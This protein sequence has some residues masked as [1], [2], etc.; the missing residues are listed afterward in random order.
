[1]SLYPCGASCILCSQ[2]LLQSSQTPLQ[3]FPVRLNSFK[4]ETCE[5]KKTPSPICR[6]SHCFALAVF[7]SAAIVGVV[8]GQPSFVS[9]TPKIAAV[10]PLSQPLSLR[11]FPSQTELIP[12]EFGGRWESELVFDILHLGERMHPFLPY[13]RLGQSSPLCGRKAAVTGAGCQ[14]PARVVQGENCMCSCN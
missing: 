8:T 11:Q 2:I 4:Q 10:S 9:V 3:P 5:E 13:H 1:M 7:V 12:Q 6:Y 14:C